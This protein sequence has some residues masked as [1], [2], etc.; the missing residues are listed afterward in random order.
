MGKDFS[1]DAD[2]YLPLRD[3]VFFTLRDLIL[4]GEL[5]PGDRLMEIHLAE[6]LGVSRT[7]VREAIRLLEKEGL[8]IT[9]PR[10]GAQVAR[11]TEK[12]LSD[13]LEVREALDGLAAEK[14]CNIINDEILGRLSASMDEF[15]KAIKSD[16][17]KVIVEAD[18]AFH[19]IIYE[20]ADNPRLLSIVDNLKEQMYRFRFEYVREEKNYD[21]L[22]N[23]HFSIIDGL[24][25][26]DVVFVKKMMHTHLQNQIEAVRRIIKNYDR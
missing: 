3:E 25:K 24:R 18:E 11:M 8:A 15:K 9:I 16:D 2:S 1:L 21:T 7:P 23:E 5:S 22:I 6:K 12:D 20:A 14:A 19:R 10:R 13:V 4:K 17:P 26:K